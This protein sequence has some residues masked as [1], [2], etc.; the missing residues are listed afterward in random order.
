M[1]EYR[2][3]VGNVE[4]LCLTDAETDLPVPLGEIFPNVPA[5]AWAPLS[6]EIPGGVQ[7]PRYL[8]SP[9]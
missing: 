7:R 2:L 6:T 4:V 1:P 8:P 9:F 5:D 3:S